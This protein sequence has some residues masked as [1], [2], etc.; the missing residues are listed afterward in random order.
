MKIEIQYVNDPKGNV[1]SVQV[2]LAEWE[3]ILLKL[4]KYE[5]LLKLKSDFTEAFEQVE[6]LKKSKAKKQ[7][8]KDFLDGL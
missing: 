5:Q 1:R 3:K 6:Q 8:L 7:T 4:R 2:P